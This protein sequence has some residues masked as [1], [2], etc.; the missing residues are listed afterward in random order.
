[1]RV[2]TLKEPFATLISSGIKRTETRS[3]KT[4]YRGE[5][6]IHVGIKK[7]KYD[8]KTEEFKKIADKYKYEKLGFIICKCN[9]VDC[10]EM[11]EE[12]IDNMKK[13]HYI[14]YLCGEYEVGRFSWVLNDIEPIEPIEAKGKLGIWHFFEDDI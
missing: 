11:T 2:L 14:D 7:A 10:I 12:Y 13:N 5:L 1:M 8:Y 4:K 3:W 6:Y 9:L